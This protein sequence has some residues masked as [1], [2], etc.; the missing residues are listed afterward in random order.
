M[1]FDRD[2]EDKVEMSEEEKNIDWLRLVFSS[3]VI[4]YF[5]ESIFPLIERIKNYRVLTFLLQQRGKL[6][7]RTDADSSKAE[8]KT[9]FKKKFKNGKLNIT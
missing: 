2:A 6:L 5:E 4:P 8:N 9:S 1:E 7:F 3:N